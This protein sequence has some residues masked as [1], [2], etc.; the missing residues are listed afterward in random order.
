M[1]TFSL[2]PFITRDASLSMDIKGYGLVHRLQL[3][4]NSRLKS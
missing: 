1:G 4:V 2:K 3:C